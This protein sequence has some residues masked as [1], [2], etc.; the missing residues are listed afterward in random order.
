M[1]KKKKTAEERKNEWQRRREER[2]DPLM[3]KGMRGI[4]GDSILPRGLGKA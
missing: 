2:N 1:F 4:V 3:E